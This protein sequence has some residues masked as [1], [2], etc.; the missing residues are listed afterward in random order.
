LHIFFGYAKFSKPTTEDTMNIKVEKTVPMP[1]RTGRGAPCKYP[2]ADMAVGDSFF[3]KGQTSA[4]LYAAGQDW[5]DRR[6][7][8]IKFATRTENDGA[9][10]WRIK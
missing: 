3:V 1:S 2:W 5:G 7:P 10:I 4:R 8:P 6:D 9:R